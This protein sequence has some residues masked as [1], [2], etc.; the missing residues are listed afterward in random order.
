MKSIY[1]ALAAVAASA[2]IALAMIQ[3]YLAGPEHLEG[4]PA[5]VYAEELTKPELV[6]RINGFTLRL[7][8]E[9]LRDHAWENLV[10]SPFNVY[11]AL[12]LLYEGSG[13]RTLE[14]VG[15]A[16]MLH[17]VNACTAYRELLSALPTNAGKDTALMIA[18]GAWL[19]QDLRVWED[20][21]GRVKGCYG[22]E[23]RHFSD[24]YSAVVDIN[25]WVRGKTCGLI[26][27]LIPPSYVN[28][29]L[30]AVLVSAIYFRAEWVTKFEPY[31]NLTFHTPS[32][33]V[34]APFME[35]VWGNAGYYEGDGYRALMLPYKNTSVAMVIIMPDDPSWLTTRYEEM[36]KE[37]INHFRWEPV[38]G[39][40]VRV[41]MPKFEIR[42]G[43]RGPD[44]VP[45]L[46][47]LGIREAFDP[48]RANFSRMTP[49]SGVY[50]G[51]VLHKAVIRVYENG[52]EAAAA[53]ASMMFLSA[54][55]P[56]DVNILIN[57]P[58]LYM[59]WDRDSGTII[60]IGQ[61]INPAE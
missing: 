24:P 59:L 43:D 60:F 21:V 55:P 26:D 52:T 14:E 2:A 1:L 22:A 45:Y 46:R 38:Y 27:Q 32:E 37:A 40:S 48:E 9:V 13:G 29:D 8:G 41:V 7:Y 44:I 33:D 16:L 49:D 6:S 42:F 54:P 31:G 50:V 25:S 17:D 23:V 34:K 53:T 39:G 5:V 30:V 4:G 10:L 15:D 56:A 61:L 28:N 11:V 35:A 36:V 58:F 3:P 18:N 19:R 57:R 47:K 51:H 12:T 20:Y